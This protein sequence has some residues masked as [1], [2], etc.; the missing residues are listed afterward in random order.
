MF[1]TD[2]VNFKN[3]P[4]VDENHWLG[5]LVTFNYEFTVIAGW[6]T[7]NVRVMENVSGQWNAT[8]INVTPDEFKS[9]K[10]LNALVFNDDGT[11]SLFIFGM[12]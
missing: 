5:L 11:D 8:K 10:R 1:S 9:R 2:L 4:D 7:V 12:L 6:L 3:L